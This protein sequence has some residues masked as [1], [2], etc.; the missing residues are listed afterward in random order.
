[1]L[2]TVKVGASFTAVKLIV[3]V[4]LADSDPSLTAVVSV[5]LVVLSSNP[6]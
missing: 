4:A 3:L 1:V 6:R 5:R 2:T